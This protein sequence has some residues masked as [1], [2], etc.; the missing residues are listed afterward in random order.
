[1][2]AR[3]SGLN[4]GKGLQ[5]LIPGGK[6]SVK[7]SE[8][9]EASSYLKKKTEEAVK[10]AAEKSKEP[11]EN[12]IVEIRISLVIPDYPGHCV[13]KDVPSLELEDI[14]KKGL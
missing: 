14:I 4:M 1:M 8:P 3:K 12:E 2:A 13:L 7:S 6:E 10:K 9:A 11:N 5:N